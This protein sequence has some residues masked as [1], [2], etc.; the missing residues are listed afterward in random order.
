MFDPS[1]IR[2][3]VAG[4]TLAGATDDAVSA[5]ITNMA[6]RIG[7]NMK[8]VVCAVNRPVGVAAQKRSVRR[9]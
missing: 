2:G 9:G 3:S 7:T 6:E 5:A 1:V 4:L 8:T